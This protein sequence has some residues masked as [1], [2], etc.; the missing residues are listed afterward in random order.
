MSSAAGLLL[1]GA[2]PN[3]YL[4]QAG[5]SA[6]AY[7]GTEKDYDARERETVRGPAVSLAFQRTDAD[8][9]SY[10]KQPRSFSESSE[11]TEGGGAGGDRERDRPP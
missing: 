11:F 3:R 6:A 10:P 5:V 7:A 2:R 4:P 9:T 1:V 8:G